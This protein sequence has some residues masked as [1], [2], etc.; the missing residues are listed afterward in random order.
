MK[1]RL[2][3]ATLVVMTALLLGCRH[4]PKTTQFAPA[5]PSSVVESDIVSITNT[6]D[7]TWLKPSTNLFT[8]GPGDRLEIEMVGDLPSRMTT[9]VAPDGKLYFSLLPGVDVWGLTIAEAK[10][11]LEQ[12]FSEYLRERPRVSIILR[13][14]E[15]KRVW[16]LGR[17]QVP[18][19]YSMAAPM[20]LLEAVSMAGGT[21]ALTSFRD[22]AAAGINEELADLRRSFVLRQGKRLPV[23]F[24]RLINEGDLTQNIYLQPDD[25]V[26]FPGAIAREVYVFGAVTQP[27]GVPYTEDLTV[28]GAI[29][30]SFGTLKDAY[31]SHVAVVR[32]SL[33][34]PQITVLDYKKVVRGEARDVVLQA[35]DIVYVPFSPYRYLK[36]YAELIVNTFV[37]STAINAGSYAVSTTP[38]LPAGIFIPAGSGIQVIPPTAPPPV[39]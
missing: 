5:T 20:T 28:A 12:G 10:D 16:V 22:Q 37:S 34:E 25:F 26:Y 33:T 15:S 8:L 13:A 31:L 7:P 14:V 21:M 27:R 9:V 4:T 19:V 39:R 3:L 32:G 29:A 35:G 2:L 30:S 17:V 23:D 38:V 18:G 24:T 6:I 36:R 1:T 11:K